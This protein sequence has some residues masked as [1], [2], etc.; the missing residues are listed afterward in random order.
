MGNKNEEILK[1]AI[2]ARSYASDW[3]AAKVEWQLQR[4]YL[5]DVAQGCLCSHRPIWYL[6]YLGN[7]VTG[8]EALIGSTCVT[9]WFDVDAD[10]LFQ[11]L[12]EIMDD[13]SKAPYTGLVTLHTKILRSFPDFA[14]KQRF[15]FGEQRSSSPLASIV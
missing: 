13:P 5:S 8:E 14:G 10:K 6:C 2:L 12:K 9:K 11:S 7:N 3:H 4:I 1:A 15:A